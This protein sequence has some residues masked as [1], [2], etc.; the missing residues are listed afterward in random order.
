MS[1]LKNLKV[2][3]RIQDPNREYSVVRLNVDGS[4]KIFGGDIN[5][6]SWAGL[7]YT[8]EELNEAGFRKIESK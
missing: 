1:D 5:S 7:N 2:G 6:G 3:D 8:V 4:V